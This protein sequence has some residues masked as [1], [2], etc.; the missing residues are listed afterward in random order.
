MSNVFLGEPSQYIRNWFVETFI[1]EDAYTI[2]ILNNGSTRKIFINGAATWQNIGVKSDYWSSDNT[3]TYCQLGKNVTEISSYA[4]YNCNSLTSIDI[5]NSVSSI[6]S[7]A[8][9]GCS[10]LTSINIPS[11]V[12]SIGNA[13]FNGCDSLTSIN[14][15]SSITEIGWGILSGCS[16]LT[17][18]TIPNSVTSIGP[19]A[20]YYCSSLTSID[21]PSSVISIGSG[22]FSECNSLTSIT[23]NTFKLKTL[24]A[25]VFSGNE[26]L[27]SITQRGKSNG[28]GFYNIED[29]AFENCKSLKS[30]DID[31]YSLSTIGEYVFEGCSSLTSINFVF[32]DG[33]T[34]QVSARIS[35]MPNYPF[36]AD[37]SII[38]LIRGEPT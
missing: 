8:F 10:S 35:S 3:L 15:P 2:L 37:P 14:I 13:T 17:S 33:T 16:S 18:I 9:A 23:F 6:G 7:E 19:S 25:R 11:S 30:L 5:P 28:L 27:V 4:F 22:A 31:T 26:K 32:G 1:S 24:P 29:R 34:S 12:T 20:F 21:I 38:K 36:G